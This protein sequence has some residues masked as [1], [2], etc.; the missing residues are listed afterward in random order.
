M[1]DLR[2]DLTSRS[3][4]MSQHCF[5]GLCCPGGLLGASCGPGRAVCPP[6][7]P[8]VPDS[9]HAAPSARCRSPTAQSQP[10]PCR[11]QAHPGP[12]DFTFSLLIT[13]LLSQLFLLLSPSGPLTLRK[14]HGLM[15]VGAMATGSRWP[16]RACAVGMPPLSTGSQGPSE[17]Q[18]CMARCAVFRRCINP[19]PCEISQCLRNGQLLENNLGSRKLGQTLV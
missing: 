11:L 7:G 16:G 2:S 1:G 9:F 19:G 4:F 14:A 8:L 5:G 3:G 18:A 15:R 17:N 6:V 10:C 12:R 13:V